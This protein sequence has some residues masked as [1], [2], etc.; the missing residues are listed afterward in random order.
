M[1]QQK[2]IN[3]LQVSLT[4]KQAAILWL[5]EINKFPNLNEYVDFLRTQPEGNTPLERLPNQVEQAVREAMKGRPK[6]E[7]WTAVRLAV[8]D[9]A[10]LV[11]LVLNVNQRAMSKEREW[12]LLRMALAHWLHSLIL[13][14]FY[15][16]HHEGKDQIRSWTEGV[17]N[18]LIELYSYQNAVDSISKYY[19][20][21]C[22]VLFPEVSEH[23]K[24][25]TKLVE[26]QVE[27]FNDIFAG[28][29][30]RHLRID[31]DILRD[32]VKRMPDSCDTVDQSKAEALV[33]IGEHEAA[34][35]LIEKLF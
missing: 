7:V 16:K 17:E 35:E 22:Q 14:R 12:N 9:V 19:L 25:V 26:N 18:S 20:D 29:I 6:G 31:L 23:L 10:F 13:E 24:I 30:K 28:K 34:V 5:Q 11:H 4:P 33:F 2:R 1:S 21:G 32:A 15:C 8:R 3:K 27:L